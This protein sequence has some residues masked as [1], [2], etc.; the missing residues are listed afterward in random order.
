M[1]LKNE[2][3]TAVVN[4]PSVFEPLKF[5]YIV[6]EIAYICNQSIQTSTFPEKWKEAKVTP[7]F[8]KGS[9]EDVNNFRPISILPTM[10]KLLEKHVHDSL[11]HHVNLYELLHKMHSG[12]RFILKIK[13]VLLYSFIKGIGH[14]L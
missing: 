11:M 8:K 9:C 3:K 13:H 5:Y 12:F 6:N 1:G 10:S 7:L 4:E 14:K 2:F